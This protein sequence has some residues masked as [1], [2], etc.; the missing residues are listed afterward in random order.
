MKRQVRGSYVTM[1]DVTEVKVIE[2]PPPH[3]IFFIGTASGILALLYI[4][5]KHK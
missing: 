4:L 3:P 1:G 5:F 2:T